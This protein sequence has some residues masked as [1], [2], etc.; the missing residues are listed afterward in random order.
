[1]I[2]L[3]DLPL[4]CAHLLSRVLT[5]CSP[6]DYS[7]PDSSVHEIFQ[8]RILGWVA[9]F[10]S[11]GIFLTQGLNLHLLHWQMDSLPMRYLRRIDIHYFYISQR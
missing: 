5:L 4:L 7:P 8:A 1:M 9:I 3:V 10:F 6:M 2:S 11:S